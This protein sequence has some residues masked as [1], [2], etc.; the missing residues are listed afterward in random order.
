[1]TTVRIAD[2]AHP[3]GEPGQSPSGDDGATIGP[4]F[5]RSQSIARSNQEE[6]HEGIY[7]IRS[8]S[9]IPERISSRI[10]A[11]EQP[12]EDPGLRNPGDFMQRQVGST[13]MRDR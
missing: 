3:G 2:P 7:N 11:A 12:D 9:R 10:S 1:M 8:H 5:S 4:A 13:T 6:T